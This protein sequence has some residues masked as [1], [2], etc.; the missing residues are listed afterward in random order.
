[1]SDAI[2]TRR[3]RETEIMIK[4]DVEGQGRSIVLSPIGFL[5][6]MLESF[7]RHGLFD[8]EADISGDVHVDQ[9]HTVEDTGIALG[10]AFRNC[11]RE[12][13]GI[14]RFG[15]ALVPMDESLVLVAI[16]ISGR[17]YLRMD[18]SFSSEKA[19]DLYLETLEDFFQGFVNALGATLHLRVFYGRSDHHI[20]EAL[21]KALGKAMRK[22]CEEEAR[23][24]NGVLST[25]G[26][27]EL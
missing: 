26:T 4:L 23:L 27:L 8:L 18:A 6:H 17:P 2:V 14:A 21:F 7:A 13:K 19:G 20:I 15:D 1:M 9:H 12:R 10:Q 22:A 24:K 16:D 11:L 25:K 5:N 3:T